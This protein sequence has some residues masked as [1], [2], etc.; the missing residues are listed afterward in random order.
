MSADFRFARTP[1][2]LATSCSSRRDMDSSTPLLSTWSRSAPLAGPRLASPGAALSSSGC[3]NSGRLR[4]A[5]RRG[6]CGAPRRQNAP[7]PG[8]ACRRGG[9][10][11]GGPWNAHAVGCCPLQKALPPAVVLYV[12]VCVCVCRA[13]STS[14]HR[15]TMTQRITFNPAKL[16]VRGPGGRKSQQDC[17]SAALSHGGHGTRTVTTEMRWATVALAI[18][19]TPGASAGAG[20]AG[21]AG[22]VSAG[23]G[24]QGARFQCHNTGPTQ[25]HSRGALFGV[26]SAAA[27]SHAHAPLARAPA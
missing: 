14:T 5:H 3:R 1:A 9:G 22:M 17:K 24:R 10:A 8:G 13:R 7:A 15:A 2:D 16:H 12:C 21:C 25:R 23:A 18:I 4:G 6:A 11:T 20:L 26:V 27:H 19:G